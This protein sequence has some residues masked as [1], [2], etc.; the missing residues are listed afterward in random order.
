MR[1]KV[2]RFPSIFLAPYNAVIY[3]RYI[4]YREA[5]SVKRE[6]THRGI[7]CIGDRTRWDCRFSTEVIA[8]I[9]IHNVD[10]TLLFYGS[11]GAKRKEVENCTLFTFFDKTS[12][13]RLWG[14]L[15][16]FSVAL[17]DVVFPKDMVIRSQIHQRY[18]GVSFTEEGQMVSYNRKAE[19]RESSNGIGFFMLLCRSG[20]TSKNRQS[21]ILCDVPPSYLVKTCDWLQTIYVCLNI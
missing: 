4:L 3:C 18:I 17:V 5:D 15:H 6:I 1:S 19:M 9:T 2:V 10:V 16:D 14:D 8:M 20:K 11:L 21:L 7:S 13:V 12:H